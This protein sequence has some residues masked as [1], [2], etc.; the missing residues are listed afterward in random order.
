M[1]PV[2][3]GDR[4]SKSRS[5]LFFSLIKFNHRP[6]ADRY[7][8]GRGNSIYDN[9]SGCE[10]MIVADEDPEKIGQGYETCAVLHKSPKGSWLLI[11]DFYNFK[12][13]N[14]NES[15]NQRHD[16]TSPIGY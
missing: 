6:Q 14:C 2:V 10:M 3:K 4:E 16:H 13:P 9:V 7:R 1:L 11:S 12:T 8:N 15:H 5:S